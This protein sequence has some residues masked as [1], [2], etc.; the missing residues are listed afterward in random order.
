MVDIIIPIHNWRSHR[1]RW[2]RHSGCPGWHDPQVARYGTKGAGKKAIRPTGPRHTTLLL[3]LTII[4]H[5]KNQR[6][7][8]SQYP[9]HHNRWFFNITLNHNNRLFLFL[10][11]FSLLNRKPKKQRNSPNS[12]KLR[13]QVFPSFPA[14][15]FCLKQKHSISISETTKSTEKPTPRKLKKQTNNK[16][17]WLLVPFLHL[18]I[19]YH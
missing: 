16:T 7:Q 11:L 10:F 14:L 8:N 4:P 2:P 18:Q 17:L 12:F 6:E 19:L 15:F 1:C 3:F 5:P 13:P 9:E